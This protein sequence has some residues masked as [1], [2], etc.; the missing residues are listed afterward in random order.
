VRSGDPYSSAAEIELKIVL[1]SIVIVIPLV[2][3]V[4][5]VVIAVVAVVGPIV[6]VVMHILCHAIVVRRRP[7]KI[8]LRERFSRT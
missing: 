7:G 1:F 4:L 2:A 3:T 6:V 5:T 8:S